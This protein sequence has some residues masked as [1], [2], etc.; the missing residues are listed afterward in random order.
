MPSLTLSGAEQMA[1]DALLLEQCWTKG[2]KQPVLRFYRWKRPS[3]S[4]GQ[5]PMIWHPPMIWHNF[6]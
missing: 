6:K 2:Q 4:L 3:L 1:L 5:S